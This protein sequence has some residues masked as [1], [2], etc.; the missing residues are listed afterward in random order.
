MSRLYWIDHH[1]AGRLAIAA[2]PQAGDRLDADLKAWTADGV[3]VVV[4]LLEEEEASKLGLQREPESCASNG[5][6]FVSFPIPDF[7]LPPG[8]PQAMQLTRRLAAELEL[9]RTI[10]I[11]CRGGIGRSSTM[12]ACTLISCGVSADDALSRIAAARGR[13]VPETADQRDWVL[14]F[15]KARTDEQGC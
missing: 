8:R 6:A 13:R 14:S 3:D 9:G 2:R 12:A 7:G 10:V 11:H 1:G 15:A 4:S 5:L